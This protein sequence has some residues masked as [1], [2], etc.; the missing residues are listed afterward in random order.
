MQ[1]QSEINYP[2][3]FKICNG[4]NYVCFTFNRKFDIEWMD[5]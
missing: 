3:T 4:R 2:A 1:N 5:R